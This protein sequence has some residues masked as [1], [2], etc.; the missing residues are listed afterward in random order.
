M[1]T[2]L[3]Q[4]TTLKNWEWPGGRGYD[5]ELRSYIIK[6]MD[7]FLA[8]K[9]VVREQLNKRVLEDHRN[10]IAIEIGKYWETLATFIGV[11]PHEVHDIIEV[12]PP[13]NPNISPSD[14]R[15]ALMRRW[16]ELYGS[17][18]TYLKLVQG[19]EQI[20]KRD[21]SELLIVLAQTTVAE[22]PR[23][24]QDPRPHSHF[25]NCSNWNSCSRKFACFIGIVFALMVIVS[26]LGAGTRKYFFGYY[27]IVPKNYESTY[28][29][30]HTKTLSESSHDLIQ[31]SANPKQ[32]STWCNS[33]D[34]PESD[35]PVLLGPF[36]GRDHDLSEVTNKAQNVHIVNINGA[37][38][39]GKSFLGMHL[40]YKIVK[41]GTPVRYVN[42]ED[43]LVHFQT[44][45]EAEQKLDSGFNRDDYD[46]HHEPVW[47]KTTTALTKARF[48]LT[49]PVSSDSALES[50]KT[51]VFEDLLKW[52]KILNC[53]TFLILD[54][55]DDILSSSIRND[56][57]RQVNL[58]IESSRHN[59]HIILVSQE[60][61][62][63]LDFFDSWT[64]KEL[65]EDASIELLETLA[66]GIGYNQAKI[67]ADLVGRCPLALKVV[68]H[69]L[70]RYGD[71]LTEK[72]EEE[73]EQS[74]IDVLDEA[75]AKKQ[76]FRVI[77][78]IV[79]NRLEELKE[80]GYAVSL[81]PGSFS[82]RAGTA[83]L[84]MRCLNL[85]IKHSLL[86]EYL[87]GYHQRYKM[88]RLIREY[89]LERVSDKDKIEFQHNFCLYYEE[90]LL[91]FATNSTV[92]DE[93]EWHMLTLEVHNIF[94][95]LQYI[96]SKEDEISV[97]Q[98]VI[99][100][101]SIGQK[102][103]SSNALQ[104]HSKLF[105]E[106]LNSV[107]DHLEPVTCGEL[108]A[109][110]VPQLY[111]ECRCHSFKEYIQRILYRPCLQVFSCEAVYKLNRIES[112]WVQLSEPEKRFVERLIRYNC[113]NNELQGVVFSLTLWSA[114]IL[115][116]TANFILLNVRKSYFLL[117]SLFI[118][119]FEE[120]FPLFMNESEKMV[121]IEIIP[122]K[123]FC[124]AL[125]SVAAI[126]V[127][128]SLGHCMLG[129]HREPLKMRL[130]MM[131][132]AISIVLPPFLVTSLFNSDNYSDY[133][134][135]CPF[136]PIC[137]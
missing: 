15:L 70:H 85:F 75:S 39:F 31:S 121:L 118:A 42:I 51:P 20:G 129:L 26:V 83:I 59:L 30:S 64:V 14:R 87:H 38:G 16:D 78:N 27:N 76:Q 50:E 119:L 124:H 40:G 72:L 52:S 92:I 60:K 86:D 25:L 1:R 49:M 54:N 29:G 94:I 34:I 135:F 106:N 61:L 113:R 122:R 23:D 21:I 125:P 44:P 110:I 62:V 65:G 47:L 11:P 131:I 32:S 115:P 73:L 126:A 84:S 17:E 58:L 117:I 123:L 114:L 13:E 9:G 6:N 66:P 105:M 95:Y 127:L 24:Q 97:N 33:G 74:P 116:I 19:L 71:K 109:S 63:L 8:S 37:P 89:F 91:K 93:S 99:L 18:A 5:P 68:G 77:M 112:I 43:K 130:N 108:Y 46:F 104:K 133:T 90:I 35:L 4:P 120:I 102:W 132:L 107:C 134:A 96:L 10:T 53:T 36:V 48:T 22:P 98:L 56:F 101:F 80:C 3:A 100:G 79:F 111:Q 41:N 103:M 88:H 57:F 28:K 12:Y 81:F 45:T 55:C 7:S 128:L 82:S 136:L 67:V 69:L 2:R 137:Y